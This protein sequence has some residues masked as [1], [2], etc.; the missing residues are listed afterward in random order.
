[1]RG[2]SFNLV[3]AQSLDFGKISF[4]EHIILEEVEKVLEF[5]ACVLIRTNDLFEFFE[6][7]VFSLSIEHYVVE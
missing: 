5:L 2:Q 4:I 3:P 6:K 7:I 1:M